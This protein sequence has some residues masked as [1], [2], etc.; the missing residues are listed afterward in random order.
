MHFR[1]S[2]AR[3]SCCFACASIAGHGTVR[4]P[5][6]PSVA[7][8]SKAFFFSLSSYSTPI[9]LFDGL[10]S[11]SG[12]LS[13][14]HQHP[15]LSDHLPTAHDKAAPMAALIVSILPASNLTPT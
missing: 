2:S 14:T 12:A 9:S 3:S 5:S 1:G 7:A 10:T 6:G 11:V 15:S 8:A 4:V 13:S